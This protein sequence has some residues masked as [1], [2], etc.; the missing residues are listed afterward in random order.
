MK[1]IWRKKIRK[2]KKNS[3]KIFKKIKCE[4]MRKI[5]FAAGGTG[6]HIFP[7]LAIAAE[8]RKKNP[9]AKIEFFCARQKLDAAI[10]RDAG[11][12]FAPIFCGKLRRYFSWQNFVDPFFLILGIFQCFFKFIFSRPALIFSKGGFA[13]VPP[14]FAAALL[15]IPIISHES[16]A[17]PGLAN[18]IC[19]RFS[20]KIFTAFPGNFGEFSGLPVSEKI[21]SAK[22]SDGEKILN[23]KNPA[24][25][26]IFIFG[27][28]QG[29]DFLNN[30]FFSLAEKFSEIANFVLISGDKK[31][32]QPKNE[33][34]K[35]FDFLPHE[36]F[37]AVLHAADIVISRAG[38]SIFEL[39]V[40]K[41]CAIL[42]PHPHGSGHQQ[43]N[44]EIFAAAGAAKIF[45]QQNFELKNL[46]NFVKNLLENK[47]LRENFSEK[48]AQFAPKNAAKF[49]A[50][51]ILEIGNLEK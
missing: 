49:L 16:D 42:V 25:K 24:K 34:Q 21:F 35:I 48:I 17:A 44:A 2:I 14:V 19:G 18:K 40:T 41:K 47:N 26:I 22:K 15:R 46:E 13:A 37:F 32:L 31:N 39:A 23:F 4:K 51:K 10:L 3:Q 1:K 50:E 33:S 29:A 5:V 36:K 43:K 20:Q 38:S 27:G 30:I 7:A 9:A 45:S 6:G 8:I 12:K 28:S 11:E